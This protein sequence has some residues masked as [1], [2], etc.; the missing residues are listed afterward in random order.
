[1]KVNLIQRKIFIINLCPLFKEAK[2]T[3]L[4]CLISSRVVTLVWFTSPLVLEL[5]QFPSQIFLFRIRSSHGLICQTQPNMSVMTFFV[6][7]LFLL[8]LFGRLEIR[9]SLE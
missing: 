3:T 9:Q 7:L 1:M 8:G 2:E 5:V 6:W 4:H